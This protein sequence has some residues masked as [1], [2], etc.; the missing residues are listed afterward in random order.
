MM[1]YAKD[2]RQVA[3]ECSGSCPFHDDAM[4]VALHWRLF[5]DIARQKCKSAAIG[6]LDLE[7][8][9]DRAAHSIASLCA[10]RWGIPIPVITCLLTTIQ[11]MVFFLRTAHGDSDSFYSAATD[12]ETHCQGNGGGRALFL[13]TSSPCVDY[14]HQ[15]G[16]AVRLRSAFSSTVFCVIGILYVDNTNLLVFAEYATESAERV[17]RRMQDMMTHWRGC[18]RVTGGNLNPEKCNWTPIGFYWDSDGQWHYRTNIVSSVCIP[19]ETGVMQEIEM[20]G[21]SQATRV[22]GVV[23]VAD[24]SM[25]EQVQALKET[26]DDIGTRINKGYLPRT[27][28]WQSLRTQVWPSI[29]FPLAATTILAEESEMITKLLYSQLLPSGGTNRHFPLVYRHAP[30]TFFGLTLP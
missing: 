8:C 7:Q 26:A 14:M 18:L 28:V 24:G 1:H 25:D 12:S 22:V 2:R 21:P 6:S 13:A 30:F 5:C 11:L 23:Q 20:L 17:A 10:Q 15:K 4:E 16:F 19:D 3:E 9:F 27:L 29:C